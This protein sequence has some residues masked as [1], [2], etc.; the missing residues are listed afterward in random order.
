M[1]RIMIVDDAPLMRTLLASILTE[2]GF[3]VIHLAVN[4][5]E[6]VEA[7]PKAKPDVVIMDVSMPEM[8]G[9]DAL[10]LILGADPEAKIIMCST[11]G[12]QSFILKAI[13][14]GAKDFIAKP[15]SP[16][17]VIDAVRHVM[18]R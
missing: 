8:N 15:F 10:K 5:K 16:Y 3:E 9:V 4:G 7:Y 11:F 6:A 17:Q 13:E 14:L 18:G 12:Q 1:T 2:H